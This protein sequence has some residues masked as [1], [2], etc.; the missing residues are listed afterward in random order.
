MKAAMGTDLDRRVRALLGDGDVVQAAT[1]GLRELGPR[2]L[3]YLRLLLR[4]EGDVGDA[5]SEFAERLWTGLSSFRGD[6]SFSAWALRVAYSAAV[7]VR[8]DAWH[9]RGRRLQT[10]D[11]SMLAAEILSRTAESVQ[12]EAAALDRLRESLPLK[13][14]ALLVLRID[15]GL[16][17]PEVSDALST[18]AE[19]V[20]ADA[21]EKRFERLKRRLAKAAKA[22]GLLD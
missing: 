12:R 6:G 22:Q 4:N 17:W 2:V 9:R 15:Q 16:S 7:D 20:T 14:Q 13:D 1:E 3:R 5:F 18:D 19:R 10:G 21:L 11:A 8:S